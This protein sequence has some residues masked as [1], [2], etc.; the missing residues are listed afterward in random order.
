MIS[1]AAGPP[2]HAEIDRDGTVTATRPARETRRRRSLR[3]DGALSREDGGPQPCR[4]VARPSFGAC[5]DGVRAR[6]S[7]VTC[8]TRSRR[9]RRMP[10]R[11]WAHGRR[12]AAAR[13]TARDAARRRAARWGR[14]ARSPVVDADR[15][16]A[17]GAVTEQFRRRPAVI[18]SPHDRRFSGNA[19]QS[20][21]ALILALSDHRGLRFPPMCVSPPRRP[22]GRGSRVRAT[23]ARCSSL[24]LIFVVVSVPGCS[25]VFLVARSSV[26]GE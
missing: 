19:F 16:G 7:R 11:Q 2:S 4:C 15:A 22:A 9:A 1:S 6:R 3:G 8:G 26:R 5:R 17:G 23:Q 25:R 21:H 18:S 24:L 12:R 13:C 14:R 20:R 10:A